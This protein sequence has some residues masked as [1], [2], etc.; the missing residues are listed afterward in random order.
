MDLTLLGTGTAHQSMQRKETLSGPEVWLVTYSF[1]LRQDIAGRRYK[2][3]KM[4]VNQTV[5]AA[6]LK[7]SEEGEFFVLGSYGELSE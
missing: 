5:P 7:H 4:C 2:A 6:T 3:F 1:P